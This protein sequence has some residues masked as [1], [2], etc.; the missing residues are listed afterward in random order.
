MIEAVDRIFELSVVRESN[1][2]RNLS[3]YFGPFDVDQDATYTEARLVRKLREFPRDESDGFLIWTDTLTTLELDDSVVDD[4]PL[5]E[6]ETAYYS[7]FALNQDAEWKEKARIHSLGVVQRIEE[8]S[9]SFFSGHFLLETDGGKDS[10]AV[11]KVAMVDAVFS[12]IESLIRQLPSQHDIDRC[13]PL[14]LEAKSL[15]F[16]W[17]LS[18]IDFFE[19]ARELLK[20]LKELMRERGTEAVEEYF[21]ERVSHCPIQVHRG[22][23]HRV[24]TA[25]RTGDSEV[26]WSLEERFSGL[27]VGGGDFQY[28]GTVESPYGILPRSFKTV[29]DGVDY[30]DD[31][32]NQV[33][34]VLGTVFGAVDYVAGTFDFTVPSSGSKAVI[35]YVTKLNP[36]TAVDSWCSFTNVGKKRFFTVGKVR[37]KAEV[38]LDDFTDVGS[39]EK[40]FTEDLERKIRKFWSAE[41]DTKFLLSIQANIVGSAD[42]LLGRLPI[43]NER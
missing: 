25:S 43:E 23:Y 32:A 33:V 7:M 28:T 5:E 24:R 37:T 39:Y 15:D 8:I 14:A 42:L 35:D 13:G 1:G 17:P 29:L 36:H 31:G 16:D 18:D 30:F 40:S 12:E 11:L 3:F 22:L 9:D 26:S 27:D 10:A 20:N 2:D 4:L 6:G 34:D 19:D 38:I 21:L 41:G